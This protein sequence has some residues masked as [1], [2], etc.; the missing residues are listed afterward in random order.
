MHPR[1]E[2]LTRE[3]ELIL[4]PRGL[5]SRS[6]PGFDFRPGQL[7][8][9]N[10]VVEAMVERGSVMVEAGTGI[11]KTMAYLVPVMTGGAR[12]VI[13]TGTKTLQEQI[14]HKD[15]PQ[16]EKALGIDASV[17]LM[18]GR[19]NYLCRH[20]Y[21]VQRRLA[22]ERFLDDPF[23]DRIDQWLGD[24]ETGDRAEMPD[25]P[26]DSPLWALVASQPDTCVGR[27]CPYA[28]EC[29]INQRNRRAQQADII[30]ANHHL[31]FAD[32][33][34][35]E[36]DSGARV[37]PE[38]EL[39]IFD[40]AH[41]VEA[42]ATSYFGLRVSTGQI[43]RLFDDTMRVLVHGQNLGVDT[44]ASM[45]QA[46][47]RFN[48]TARAFVKPWLGVGERGREKLDFMA[49]DEDFYR[50]LDKLK[51]ALE[52][53]RAQMTHLAQNVASP[54]L[55]TAGGPLAD[56]LAVTLSEMQALVRRNEAI[57][58][59]LAEI[60]EPD[61]TAQEHHVFFLERG[62]GKTTFSMAPISVAQLLKETLLAT[63]YGKVFT[64][65]TLSTGGNFD[66]FR[67][68][69]G[70]GPDT[71]AL[72]IPSPFHQRE[73]LRLFVP[74]DLP[75]PNT[76]AFEQAM[77]PM[78]R[79]IIQLTGGGV[80]GLFTSH[81]NLRNTAA[82]LKTMEL[83]VPLLIQGEG[84]PGRLL[85]RFRD[86]EDSVLLA[87]GT[88]WE[89]VDVK[90]Q[91]LR[92]VVVDK[93]PFDSP[94][95]PFTEARINYLRHREVDPFSAYQLPRASLALKQG[96]GRLIRGPDDWG[97]W[98]VLDSRLVEKGYGRVILS[99]LP[100]AGVVRFLDEIVNWWQEQIECRGGATDDVTDGHRYH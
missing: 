86:Q 59:G 26:D 52:N 65:A 19:A 2:Q 55:E 96:L 51:A 12:T 27:R 66:Y 77:G 87:T 8:M 9:A 94:G 85:E 79:A 57:A 13:S 47:K 1:I 84:S 80:L 72:A 40:E 88:F 37:L 71:S 35:K 48:R 23:M 95:D 83:G 7:E 33:A 6:M 98:A 15:I 54:L 22:R 73:K 28:R 42:V 92:A 17:A 53:H 18:K 44:P 36:G 56:D 64:S 11:G 45:E 81:H 14:F 20:R 99:G 41:Q 89:G 100:P 31:F 39:A 62:E 90:G 61:A 76:R 32:L 49:M 43:I 78:F 97:L 3:V 38:F 46:L 75:P 69:M 10:R 29:F 4:G 58:F 30:V 50:G 74:A 63:D 67:D 34:L 21:N 82:Q 70:L 16:L 68:Q 60:F 25:L 91:S 5:L 24:T 93:L